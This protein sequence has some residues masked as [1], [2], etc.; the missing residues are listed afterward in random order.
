M[1]QWGRM[2]SLFVC[3]FFS[4]MVCLFVCGRLLG[5]S[6]TD[7]RGA[8]RTDRRSRAKINVPIIHPAPSIILSGRKRYRH[9]IGIADIS[10]IL[11]GIGIGK[12]I[13]D[14]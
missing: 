4:L 5:P 3:L 6:Q 7:M 8:G 13:E 12:E 10:L 9:W 14:H 11:L 1:P 2:I